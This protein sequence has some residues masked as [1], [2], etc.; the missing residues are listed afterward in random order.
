MD[1]FFM[2]AQF[3]EVKDNLVY[4]DNKRKTIMDNNGKA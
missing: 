1:S 2:E 3:Y 4:Q